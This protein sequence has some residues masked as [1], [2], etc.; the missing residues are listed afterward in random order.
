MIRPIPAL[1]ILL[2]QLACAAPAFTQEVQPPAPDTSIFTDGASS[3]T[4]A[5]ETRASYLELQVFGPPGNPR[6]YDV[7]RTVL[8][9]RFKALAPD[10]NL[11]PD[12]VDDAL[13]I[14]ESSSNSPSEA[15]FRV[16][17]SLH[18]PAKGAS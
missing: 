12:A 3:A 18:P 4:G 5:T 9:K 7:V 15:H 2:A 17:V 8:Q 1:L 14:H 11:S 13:E 6:L 16:E 10:F